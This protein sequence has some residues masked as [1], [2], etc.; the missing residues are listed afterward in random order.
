MNVTCHYR[1]DPERPLECEV[2]EGSKALCLS[3][4]PFARIK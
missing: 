4:R 1:N 3:V 2:Y